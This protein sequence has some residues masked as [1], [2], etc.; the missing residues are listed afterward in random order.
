[1]GFLSCCETAQ[2]QGSLNVDN[3]FVLGPIQGC[4]KWNW[5]GRKEEPNLTAAALLCFQPW[6]TRGTELLALAITFQSS[7]YP[8]WK[9]Y[10][11]PTGERMSKWTAW[12]E[13]SS[14]GNCPVL[15]FHSGSQ[16]CEAWKQS[17][18]VSLCPA[19]SL[20][21]PD[22]SASVWTHTVPGE[23]SDNSPAQWPLANIQQSW[24]EITC[25][26]SRLC[27]VARED[28]MTSFTNKEGPGFVVTMSLGWDEERSHRI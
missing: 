2:S 19:G 5:Q 27:S 18:V 26:H 10:W 1:M 3:I 24:G 23:L 21:V 14:L 16:K 12:A 22:K 28:L 11:G 25:M 15:I 8:V 17:L 4:S 6:L 9:L 7:S 13:P 20:Y